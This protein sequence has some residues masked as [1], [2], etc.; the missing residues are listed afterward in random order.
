MQI[1]PP[2]ESSFNS[3]TNIQTPL[4]NVK[5]FLWRALIFSVLNGFTLSTQE[6]LHRNAASSAPPILPPMTNQKINTDTDF[7]I[8][9]IAMD[10]IP[11]S[12]MP[13][14]KPTESTAA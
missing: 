2:A 10:A 4:R 9:A 7:W 8:N 12:A 13:H 3:Q 6:S 14:A 5:V 1:A 11:I